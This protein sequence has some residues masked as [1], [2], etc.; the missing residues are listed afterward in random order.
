MIVT[1]II[2]AIALFA[3]VLWFINRDP[4]QLRKR[5]KDYETLVADIRDLVAPNADVDVTAELVMS[6][7][8]EHDAINR[9]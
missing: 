1:D 2:L 3:A 7:L 4:D 8:R 5:V 9:K 6:R